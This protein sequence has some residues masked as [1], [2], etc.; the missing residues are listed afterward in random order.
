MNSASAQLGKASIVFWAVALFSPVA[1]HAQASS[2]SSDLQMKAETGDAVAQYQLGLAYAEGSGV[3]QSDRSAIDWYRKAAERGNPEAQN[4]LGVMYFNGRGVEED[5]AEA[6]RRYHQAARQKNAMAMFNLGVAYYNGDRNGTGV[7]DAAAYA[8][9]KLAEQN[10]SA[11]AKEA[12]ARSEKELPGFQQNLGLLHIADM[13]LKGEELPQNIVEAE[14]WMQIVAERGDSVTQVRLARTF[15]QQEQPDYE[16][17][18][19]W[20]KRSAQIGNDDARY[21]LAD[22]YRKGLG[23]AKNP[24]EALNLF[25]LAAAHRHFASM[26]AAA[27]ML[28]TGEGGKQD[29]QQAFVY[30]IILAANGDRNAPERALTAKSQMNPKQW[31]K[32]QDRLK[33]SG[34]DPKKVEIALEKSQQRQSQ[35]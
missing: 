15:E 19:L 14:R 24:T 7:D 22:L 11:S 6:V 9:F 1:L 32:T 29:L 23:T 21:Y 27:E 16:K 33:R 25:Q 5:W 20:C 8:W 34:F 35:P 13:Y 12:V 18:F 2:P 3:P 26:E 4:S 10:G 28:L 31:K 17:A 30:F